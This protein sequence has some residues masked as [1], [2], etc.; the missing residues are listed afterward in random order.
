M[1]DDNGAFAGE[2]VEKFRTYEDFLDSQ[3]KPLDLFYLEVTYSNSRCSV[4][5]RKLD[6]YRNTTKL[7]LIIFNLPTV[8]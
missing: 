2:T 6:G 4:P 5:G 1:E 3:I 8:N 7:P